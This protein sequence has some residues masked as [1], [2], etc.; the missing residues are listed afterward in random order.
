M[1]WLFYLEHYHIILFKMHYNDLHLYIYTYF[2]PDCSLLDNSLFVLVD[3]NAN[4]LWFPFVFCESVSD[5]YADPSTTF[6]N[7]FKTN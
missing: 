1:F 7:L 2:Y 4:I 5:Y 6:L 3:D